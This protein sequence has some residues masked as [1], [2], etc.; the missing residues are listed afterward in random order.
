MDQEAWGDCFLT[1]LAQL[2]VLVEV[3]AVGGG[4]QDS[5]EVF[6]LTTAVGGLP[7]HEPNLLP[8]AVPILVLCGDIKAGGRHRRFSGIW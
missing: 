3:H 4:V 5:L 8:R 6:S 1:T 7:R 2:S